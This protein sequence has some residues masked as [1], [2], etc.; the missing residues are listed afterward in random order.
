MAVLIVCPEGSRS[1]ID[2]RNPIMP[3]PASRVWLEYTRRYVEPDVEVVKR[4]AKGSTG[5][6]WGNCRRGASGC[7]SP[8]SH[9]RDD[10]ARAV[11]G[12][13]PRDQAAEGQRNPTGDVHRG[14]QPRQ[15]DARQPRPRQVSGKTARGSR[16]PDSPGRDRPAARR[17]AHLGGAASSFDRRPVPSTTT[18][19]FIASTGPRNSCSI[20][21]D[22]SRFFPQSP[23]RCF[24]ATRM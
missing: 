23:Y 14:A 17:Y 19:R 8:R 9:R 15:Q 7:R 4:T 1:R 24:P 22:S 21:F 10:R 5:G 11:Q 16:Q 3:S 18:C 6:S 2:F 13:V 12:V 20:R